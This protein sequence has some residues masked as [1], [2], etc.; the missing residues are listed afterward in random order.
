MS[1]VVIGGDHTGRVVAFRAGRRRLVY[2][3]VP[4]RTEAP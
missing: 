3:F 2:L 4:T 1:P